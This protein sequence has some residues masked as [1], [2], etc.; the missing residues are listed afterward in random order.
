MRMQHAVDIERT[1]D[2]LWPWLTEPDR[3]TQWMKGLLE[4]SPASDGEPGVGYRSTMKIKE[5]RKVSD[6]DEEIIR[7][8]PPHGLGVRITGGSM[9]AGMAM[10]SVYTVTDLGGRSRV[11]VVTSAELKGAWK[12]FAPLMRLFAG[13]QQK[14]FFKTLKRL[15]EAEA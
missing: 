11:D 5:G 13:G 2:D 1:P 10:E 15:A 7:W 8:N 12:L 14:S 9:P 4:I 6:Y 3:L